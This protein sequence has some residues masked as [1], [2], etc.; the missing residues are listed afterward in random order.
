MEKSLK[1]GLK[2]DCLGL[3]YHVFIDNA[4]TLLDQGVQH[5]YYNPTRLFAIMDQ[6]A[7]LDIP[8]NISEITIPGCDKVGGDDMQAKITERLYRIWFSYPANSQ[9]VWWNLVDGTAAYAPQGSNEGENGFKAGLLNYDFSHKPAYEVI[10][11]LI[12]NE[13]TTNT[14]IKYEAEGVNKFHGFYGDYD[15]MIKTNNGEFKKT[16]FMYKR[17]LNNFKLELK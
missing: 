14:T 3:Q 9:I 13:W 11:N 15:I 10:K 5:S 6:Y 7:K 8:F 16:V 12:H 1:Q 17:A 4:Q 2:V